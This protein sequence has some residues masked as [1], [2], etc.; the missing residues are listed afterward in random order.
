MAKLVDL[1]TGPELAQ[2]GDLV[3]TVTRAVN[4]HIRSN[5]LLEGDPL[6]SEGAFSEELGVSR[7]VVREAFRSLSAMGLIDVGNGRRARVASID[8]DVLAMIIDH[9][10]HIDQISI[11]QIYDVRRTIEARSASLAALRRTDKDATIIAGHAAGMRRCFSE[12]AQVMEHDIAF[13][14]AIAKASRNPA[15]ALIIGSFEVVTRQTWGIG[16]RSRQSDAERMASVEAHEAIAQAIT[17]GDPQA[18][19]AAMNHHFDHSVKALIE[20]GVI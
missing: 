4:H 5:G 17:D 3:G 14:K 19:Q 2:K 13:H 12:Q 10:V 8:S 20:A 16:W 6:P 7:V 1:V 11:Q 9:A 18:A 15:F